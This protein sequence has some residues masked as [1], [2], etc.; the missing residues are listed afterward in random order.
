MYLLLVSIRYLELGFIL[1]LNIALA[2]IGLT[3]ITPVFLIFLIPE[4]FPSISIT[5][6]KVFIW[7]FKFAL[8]LTCE[9]PL[10]LLLNFDNEAF[11]ATWTAP[12]AEL[13][14]FLIPTEFEEIK[15]LPVAP[16]FSSLN[17]FASSIG[18]FMIFGAFILTT[19]PSIIE[20]CP[21]AYPVKKF[22]VS[23][24]LS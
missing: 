15:A 13:A 10:K 16:P 14:P 18:F 20:G 4:L 3:L 2:K 23:S 8:P 5:L 19:A 12:L 9:F 21:A 6:S 11:P 24:C 1:V 22:L 17:P 7:P